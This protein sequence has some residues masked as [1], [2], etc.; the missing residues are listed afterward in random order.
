MCFR[1]PADCE[2][3]RP[4][5]VIQSN[6]LP[7]LGRLI[8]CPITSE[9]RYAAFRVMLTPIGPSEGLAAPVPPPRRHGHR[10]DSELRAG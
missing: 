10:H 8:R 9:L 1:L 7:E 3:P 4:A 6:P 2:R 5:L